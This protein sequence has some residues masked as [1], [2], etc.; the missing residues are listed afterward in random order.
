MKIKQAVIILSLLCGPLLSAE[1]VRADY[2]SVSELRKIAAPIAL[3]PDEIITEIMRAAAYP[4]QIAQA[5]AWLKAHPNFSEQ[6]IEQSWN[7]FTWDPSVRLLVYSPSILQELH[8]HPE[9]TSQLNQAYTAQRQELSRAIQSERHSAWR[10][11]K[12]KSDDYTEVFQD[13]NGY[14]AVRARRGD[15]QDLASGSAPSSAA[16]PSKKPEWNNIILG[17]TSHED[18]DSSPQVTTYYNDPDYYFYYDDYDRYSVPHDVYGRPLSSP[19]DRYF[20]YGGYYPENYYYNNSNFGT[21]NFNSVNGLATAANAQNA[22]YPARTD[23]GTTGLATAANA[24]NAANP[25]RID[26][27]TTGLAT[28]A[29]A[30]NAA[31]PARI[32]SGT[33]G[34]ATAANARNAA[35]PTR[36]D[37]GTTGL[38]TAAN[39]HNTAY[40]GRINSAAAGP[41]VFKTQKTSAAKRTVKRS[42]GVAS[43][44]KTKKSAGS[45]KSRGTSALAAPVKAKSSGYLADNQRKKKI[46]NRSKK[47]VSA[48]QKG[49]TK[50]SKRVGKRNQNRQ[51][52]GVIRAA[53]RNNAR[54]A[55]ARR[56]GQRRASAPQQRTLVPV[57]SIPSASVHN[58]RNMPAHTNGGAY[59]PSGIIFNTENSGQSSGKI[60]IKDGYPTSPDNNG[61]PTIN[62]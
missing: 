36:T 23:S 5:A 37:S 58:G 26:S 54:L 29:N 28:A 20:P 30:H 12:L 35:H 14:I 59:A 52:R 48:K 42:T 16:E 47:K 55:S 22:A 56:S 17:Q 62:Q 60:V 53:K 6:Q 4:E 25:A 57:N 61:Y 40:S 13:A 33:S 19:Y 38:A 39:A 34:L 49:R 15:S 51:Q 8:E 43:A 21:K 50:S 24:R 10:S 11:S 31:Y 9:W 3:Y 41:A 32:D 44:A 27:G 2:L 45:K 46:I 1:P 18:T 7:T